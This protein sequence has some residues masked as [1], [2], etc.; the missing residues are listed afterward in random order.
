[1]WTLADT[2]ERVACHLDPSF[3]SSASFVG[4]VELA[5]GLPATLSRC[6]FLECWLPDGIARI[7]LI[8]RVDTRSRP[9]LTGDT[10][11]IASSLLREAA[12]RR[13]ADFSRAWAAP[14]GT[15][16]AYIK[17]IWLEF[18]LDAPA[19][20]V[21]R[22]PRIFVDFTLEAQLH[23]SVDERLA[24]MLDVLRPLQAAIG[25]PMVD[26]LREAFAFLPPAARIT[27]IGTSPATPGTV[28]LCIVGLEHQ[29]RDYLAALR[30]PGSMADLTASVLAPLGASLGTPAR[31][32]SM[33]HIDF[34]PTLAPRVGLEYAFGRASQR[35]GWFA[36][37]AF[38]DALVAGGWCRPDVCDS[39]T[40][41]PGRAPEWLAHEIWQ[42]RLARRV[43]HVKVTYAT[44]QPIAAKTYLCY[45]HE[46]MT[47]G[48]LIDPRPRFVNPLDPPADGSAIAGGP[49]L[50]RGGHLSNSVS[51]RLT[52]HRVPINRSRIAE[53]PTA[54]SG[55][56]TGT[57]LARILR[58]G[59]SSMNMPKQQRVLEAVLQRA[60][61]DL[62]FRQRL[63][64]TP[65]QA[66][67]EAYGVSIP[68]SFRVKFIERDSA[69][70]ALIVLPDMQVSG[71][72]LSD[73]SLESVAG[74]SGGSGPPPPTDPDW[75]DGVTNP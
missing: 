41:W 23:L 28:R 50:T 47:G 25:P 8:A 53:I 29:L 24:L 31:Q 75:D 56:A 58:P 55:N 42:T 33:L 1:M 68:S 70:D 51:A 72:A 6:V 65:R 43:S 66:I 11:G 71:S 2:L 7:D 74:G 9:W 59:G 27:S 35:H 16:D 17:G 37:R 36:E 52:G 73:E 14:G 40:H 44:G 61:V 32:A 10:P 46:L 67:Q 48:T 19:D 63:L 3:V 39:L 5:S 60:T 13:I 30:W 64:T 49:R 62:D 26:R 4:L 20:L 18:D 15:L 21:R 22:R 12:W 45:F 38:F 57:S 54:I 69:L 34:L